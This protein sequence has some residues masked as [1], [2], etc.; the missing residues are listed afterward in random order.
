MKRL[1]LPAGAAALVLGWAA[2]ASAAPL[3]ATPGTVRVTDALVTQTHVAAAQSRN[4]AGSMEFFRGLL[5]N[6][7]V[8]PAA[9]GHSDIMCVHTGTGSMNC[10]GTYFLPKGKI[11][12]GGVIGSRL[13][14]Q[15]AV[16]GGTGLYENARGTLT[17]TFLG[18]HPQ[19]EFLLF[20][21]DI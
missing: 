17:S 20:R 4:G 8:T 16:I 13:F 10:S 19:K 21:L 7:R 1:G 12:V 11:M 2:A 3:L 9:I 15:I 14:F 6:K 18:G 5:Y